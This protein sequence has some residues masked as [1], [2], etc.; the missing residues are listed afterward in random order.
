MFSALLAKVNYPAFPF[1]QSAQ[2]YCLHIVGLIHTLDLI[3]AQQEGPTNSCT[4]LPQQWHKPRGGAPQITDEDLALLR[5][6]TGAPIS[7]LVNRPPVELAV[8]GNKYPL[9]SGLSHQL[10]LVST[11][12][13]TPPANQPG[14]FPDFHLPS[15]P[16][17]VCTVLN[18][19]DIYSYSKMT[20]TL[21]DPF[22]RICSRGANYDSLA[23]S[24]KTTAPGKTKAMIRG[25]DLEPIA[26]I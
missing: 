14:D 12:R 9:G 13:P 17:H 23:A 11:A 6:Q 22:K 15:Q 21:P 4:S 16:T 18:E 25:V 2:G 20:I 24:I 10:P 1:L 5:R 26:A 8:E 19:N 3:K 7:D